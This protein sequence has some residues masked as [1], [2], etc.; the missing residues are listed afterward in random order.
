MRLLMAV[1]A[2]AAL[3]VSPADAAP[4]RPDPAGAL[5]AAFDSHAIVAKSSPDVGTFVFDLIRDPRFPGRVND[6]AV[7][8]GNARLQPLLDA[9]IFG[10]AV[11]EISHVWRDTTQPSCGFSTFYEQLFALI[12]QVNTTLP[13][14]RKIRVLAGDPPI[15]WSRVH[16]PA[17]LEPFL[18]R[19]ASI[20]SVVKTQVLQRNRKVLM[21]FGL[22]HLTHNGGSAAVAQL[23]REYPGAAYVIADHRGFTSDNARLEQRLGR[24][25]AL[26]P[27]QGSWLGS[28]ETTY[29]PVN[30]DYPPGTRGYPG[31]DAYMYEGPADLLVREPLSARAVLDTE[32]L[33]ELRRR[34]SAIDAPPDS[35]EWPETFFERE[36]SSGV[37]LRG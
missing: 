14:S 25:P 22:G 31:V 17:D 27:V 2:A 28:L 5:L 19:D 35:I 32:Y 7:E 3:L 13:S 8:C 24:W 36:R 21:L 10:A 30:R 6:V 23:E 15:D 37:L 11:P 16:T 1:L 4:Q 12:R 9:Y 34:A 20:T 26:V 33:T 29:F 18:D